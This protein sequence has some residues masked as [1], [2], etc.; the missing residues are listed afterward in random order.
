[1]APSYSGQSKAVIE[2]SHPK[3]MKNDEAPSYRV[4]NLRVAEMVRQE[5]MRT[6]T[7]NNTMNVSSR[8][9]M[10]LQSRLPIATPTAMWKLYDRLGRNDAMPVA[11]ADAVRKWLTPVDLRLTSEGVELCGRR[12]DSKALR[13]SG[14]LDRVSREQSVSPRG[15]VL[16]CCVRHIWIQIDH[17]LIELDLQVRLRGG[18]SNVYVSLEELQRE[19]ALIKRRRPT[20][21]V[22][23]RAAHTERNQEFEENTG[24]EWEPG[25]RKQGRPPKKGSRSA[26]ASEAKAAMHPKRAA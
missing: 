4:S 25:V 20:T 24:F 13:K 6:V 10:D 14:V 8:I 17:E 19:E 1:M 21:E 7:D 16:E 3:K 5:I 22:N 15:F 23:R 18:D 2:A 9:P 26:D 12:Y 11:F